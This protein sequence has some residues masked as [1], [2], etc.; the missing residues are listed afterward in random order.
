MI[1]IIN[2]NMII[3]DKP[4]SLKLFRRKIMYVSCQ[5]SNEFKVSFQYDSLFL[6]MYGYVN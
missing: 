1:V 2:L 5:K 3:K 6:F 4:L